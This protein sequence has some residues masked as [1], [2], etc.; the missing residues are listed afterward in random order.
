MNG[1]PCSEGLTE[2]TG[3]RVVVTHLKVLRQTGSRAPLW[4]RTLSGMNVSLG[5]RLHV[6]GERGNEKLMAPDFGGNE[7]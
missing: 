6:D 1:D 2:A 5:V 7:K 3:L 4:R